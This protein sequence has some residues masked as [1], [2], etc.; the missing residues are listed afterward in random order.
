MRLIITILGLIF[1]K[2]RHLIALLQSILYFLSL[3]V[4]F[5]DLNNTIHSLR[6]LT[7]EEIKFLYI[8]K[9]IVSYL[10]LSTF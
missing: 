6:A 5:F 7:E 10:F 9:Y 1:N 4:F 8:V 3:C 2:K